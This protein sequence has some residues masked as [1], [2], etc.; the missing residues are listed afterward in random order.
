MLP[1]VETV[2]LIDADSCFRYA[3]I[4]AGVRQFEI[5]QR[6]RRFG[7]LVERYRDTG[8]QSLKR[9][10]IFVVHEILDPS[11]ERRAHAEEGL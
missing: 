11:F 4:P 8:L 2:V 9:C 6:S 1:D 3:V 5:Q 7:L 10:R